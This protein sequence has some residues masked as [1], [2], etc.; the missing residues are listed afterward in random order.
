MANDNQS[1]WSYYQIAEARKALQNYY[2]DQQ[3]QQGTRLIG[4][5]IGLFTLLQLTQ[6]S[7]NSPLS[8]VFPNFPKIIN[9]TLCP[10]LSDSLK[11]V[12]LFVGTAFI[13]FFILRTIFR[14][15]LY[16]TMASYIMTVNNY[17]I[18]G[19][20]EMYALNLAISKDFYTYKTVFGLHARYFLTVG[21]KEYPHREWEGVAIL[22]SIS[23]F[24]TFLLLLFL[25]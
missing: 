8:G 23:I 25:W 2:T 14:Y 17:D 16:G 12:F 3:N 22:A 18:K 15:A 4:F 19:C 20:N 9:V 5:V 7:K 24:I 13:I 21:D 6:T 11:V 1:K 10:L